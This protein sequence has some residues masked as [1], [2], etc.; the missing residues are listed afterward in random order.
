MGWI[1]LVYMEGP[2]IDSN[3]SECFEYLVSVGDEDLWK[4]ALRLIIGS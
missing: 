3:C 4:K 1:T 2:D